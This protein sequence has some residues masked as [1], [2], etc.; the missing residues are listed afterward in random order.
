MHIL[1]AVDVARL[2]DAP[3][4]VSAL[5]EAFR[6]GC[7]APQRHHHTIGVP[8]EP[9]ATLLLMPAWT[10]GGYL[11]VKVASVF[12]GNVGTGKPAVAATYLLSDATDGRILA[13]IDG[14]EL[15]AWRTA[16]TSVLAASYLVPPHAKNLLIVGTGRIARHLARTYK[17]CRPEI[18]TVAIWGRTPSHA[19]ALAAAL[20]GEGIDAV[21]ARGL[22]AAVRE[23]D[24][25][26][27][28]T[29]A[30]EPLIEGRWLKP[31]Q[32]LDLIGSYTP[33]MREADD[34]AIAKARVVVDTLDALHESGDIVQPLQSGALR[35]DRIADLTALTRGDVPT[36]GPQEV[37][38]FKSVGCALEDL[39]AATLA[40]QRYNECIRG[41]D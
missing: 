14:G 16:A 33:A 35:R 32:H 15:T 13:A 31:G 34:A 4:L 40:Y 5:R 12:P 6:T 9:D 21:H 7:V 38:I 3:S 22:D 36:R 39:A 41:H 27:C 1:T 30:H 8:G 37:T 29:L 2:L 18:E 23:A 11:G 10:E 24:I 25:V 17:A 19:T 26:A 28:A 20:S